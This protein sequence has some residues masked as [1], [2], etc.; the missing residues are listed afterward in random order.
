MQVPLV[1]AMQ[2]IKQSFSVSSQEF[3]GRVLLWCITAAITGG[4]KKDVLFKLLESRPTERHWWII[5]QFLDEPA[6]LT[7]HRKIMVTNILVDASA[8]FD[9]DS[10][11]LDS[12]QHE[13]STLVP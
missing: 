1:I 6:I 12:Q 11:E 3:R 10:G 2:E 4:T 7:L 13:T 5:R 9:Q 8:N